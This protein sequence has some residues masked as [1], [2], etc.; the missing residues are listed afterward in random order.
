[1]NQKEIEQQLE[2]N[3]LSKDQIDYLT[4]IGKMNQ[5]NL[6]YVQKSLQASTQLLKIYQ[7]EAKTIKDKTK[8]KKK[9]KKK[10]N[11]K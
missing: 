7:D 6:D 3:N 8:Q 9:Q 10:K 1:M 5:D 11:D 2:L 4:K